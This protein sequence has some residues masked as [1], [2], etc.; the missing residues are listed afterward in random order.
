MSREIVA[1]LKFKKEPEQGFTAAALER[2]VEAGYLKHV[3]ED[4]HKQKKTFAPSS[5]GYGHGTCPR[6]WYLAFTGAEF[7][8]TTDALGVANMMNGSSAHDRLEKI[9]EDAGVLVAKE[10][11]MELKDPP[12]FGFIDVMVRIDGEVVVGELKTTRAE[13][14]MFRKNSHKPSPNHLYQI[15][16]YMQAT[17]KDKGFLF[18]ENKNDQTFLVVPVAMNVRNKQILDEA[19]EWLRLVRKNWEDVQPAE[20]E[21]KTEEELM[22]NLPTRPWTRRNKI[23]TQCPLFET[24]WEKLPA[25]NV[26]IEPMVVAKP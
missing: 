23:C 21:E 25:G 3:R 17:G 24:C 1:S 20:G 19:L 22:A 18:Y 11:K 16:I 12:I 2:A 9:F 4:E 26:L 15:L 7:K 13:A 14:F 10:I 5:I 8:E 6:Y